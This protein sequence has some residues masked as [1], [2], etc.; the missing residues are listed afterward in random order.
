[1]TPSS[2][3]YHHHQQ[4]QQRT[5]PLRVQHSSDSE[6]YD[7]IRHNTHRGK[8]YSSKNT[9]YATRNE[10]YQTTNNILSMKNEQE[11]TD[12]Y[13]FHEQN[14]ISKI[15]EQSLLLS[16]P[17]STPI[18]ISITSP[19]LIPN[20]FVQASLDQVKLAFN[21]T[22][23]QPISPIVSANNNDPWLISTSY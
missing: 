1:I 14:N 2:N 22:L 23:E 9:S 17:T 16:A 18:P 13:S 19:A 3:R 15:N 7:K 12:K 10:N 11:Q 21:R 8:T 5:V 4:Q 20:N 6:E